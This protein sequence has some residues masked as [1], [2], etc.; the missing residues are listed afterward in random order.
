MLGSACNRIPG[1]T[2]GGQ[3]MSGTRFLAGVAAGALALVGGTAAA[4]VVRLRT[5]DILEGKATDLGESVRVS[6][7]ESTVELPWS[8]VQVIDRA[9]TGADEMKARRAAC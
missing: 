2:T 6:T 9:S 7:P 4:D 1:S 3:P 8:A 5:G